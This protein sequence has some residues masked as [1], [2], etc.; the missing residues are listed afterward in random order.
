LLQGYW[1]PFY[2]HLLALIVN[3]FIN[4]NIQFYGKG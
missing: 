1:W 3:P 4:C 2:L